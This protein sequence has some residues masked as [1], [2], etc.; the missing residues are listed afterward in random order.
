MIDP[1]ERI[2]GLYDDKAEGWIADRGPALGGLG[3][4]IDEV[5]AFER[6]AA[7][8]PRGGAVLDV[9]C[10]SGWPWGAALIERGFRVTGLDASP[11]L[12]AHAAQTLPEGEW[13]VGD[14][15]AFD[16]AR[17]FDGVLVWYSLFHLTPG[18]QRRALRHLLPHLPPNGVLM[19]TIATEA[20]VSIGH[21]RGESLYHASLGAS[22]YAAILADGDFIRDDHGGRPDTGSEA[23]IL[24]RRTDHPPSQPNVVPGLDQ[25]AHQG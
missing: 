13:V 24:R 3:K 12:L 23:W 14:M 9:G 7:A 20:G 11:R 18:D 17:T 6:F 10:G 1:A 25:S 2:I 5:E 15:R 16:L 4:S 21:W 19:M 8:L 22:A